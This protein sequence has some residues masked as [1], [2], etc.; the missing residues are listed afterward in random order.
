ME[1]TVLLYEQI[2]H[3]LLRYIED[4]E[5]LPGESIPSERELAEL[6]GVSRTTIKNA[7]EVLVENEK[8]Y[9]VH[10]SGTFVANPSKHFYFFTDQKGKTKASEHSS[11]SARAK[12]MGFS[13][14]SKVHYRGFIDPSNY[15]KFITN[16]KNKKLFCLIR[17]R[18]TNDIPAVLE[19][20]YSDL[21]YDKILEELDFT[22]VSLYDYMNK[23]NYFIE[24]FEHEITLI[25]SSRQIAKALNI[26]ENDPVFLI[27]YF[28]YNDNNEFIEYTKSYIKPD[29]IRLNIFEKNKI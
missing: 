12:S 3:A 11:F 23:N 4:N 17:T 14:K 9:K 6:Y 26:K 27:E 13:T 7:I 16:N 18:Y 20:A 24:Y 15:L 28:A 22:N 1:F 25:S 2:V 21:K 8:L 29:Q 19:Y 10:G 5:L